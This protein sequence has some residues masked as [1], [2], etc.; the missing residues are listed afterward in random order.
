MLQVTGGRELQNDATPGAEA[1]ASVPAL[2][3]Y[4]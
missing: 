3:N 4:G 1:L 2:K